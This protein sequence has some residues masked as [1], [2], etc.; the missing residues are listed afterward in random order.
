MK[1]R[2]LSFVVI[3]MLLLIMLPFSA[4]AQMQE[5][6]MELEEYSGEREKLNFNQ[7]WKFI[8]KN[9][10]AAIQVDYPM[11]ELTRWT[12]VDL[13]HTVRVEPFNNSGGENYQGP[14]M[15]R[16]HFKLSQSYQGKKLFLEFEGVMGVTDVW[17]NGQHLQGAMA[18]KTGGNTQ[19][20]G[21]LPFILDVTDTVHCDGEYNVITVLTDNSD[22]L[23]V[24]PGKPQSELDFTY[25]GGIYRNVWMTATNPVHITDAVFEDMIGGGGILVDYKKVT[26]GSATAEV[27]THIRN[28]D[29]VQRDV[30]LKTEIRN[31]ED[32]AVAVEINHHK[33]AS[34]EGYTFEQSIHVVNPKLWNLDHPYMYKLV[35][36]VTVDGIQIDQTETSIG[37]RKITMN[38]DTGLRINGEPAGFLSGI[39][40]HQEYPYI[41]YAASGNLQRRDAIK[42]KSAG[43]NIVRTAH[44]PQSID[45]LNACDELG[46]LVM[47]CVPGW[48]HWSDDEEFAARVKNDIRQMVRRSRNHPSVLCYEISLNETESMPEHLKLEFP[49]ECN[50]IAKSEHPS[51][52]TSAENHRVGANS[53]I[54]YGTPSEVASWSDTAMSLI[55]EYADNWNEQNGDFTDHARVTRGP[56]T[57]YPGGEGAM[58]RQAANKLWNGYSFVGTGGISLSQGIENYVKSKHRFIGVTMW[59]GIDHNRGCE[60]T[61]SPCGL[62]D[63]RRIP[64]YSYYAF[65]SQRPVAENP[66]LETKDVETG[67]SIFIAS[68]WG[69]NAPKVD[70]SDQVIGSDQSRMIDVYSNAN[71]VK[72]SVISYDGNLLWTKTNTPI[73]YKTASYLDHPPFEFKDVPYTTGSYLKAEGLDSLDK[74]IMTKEMHTAGEPSQL[75]LEVDQ[76]GANLVADGSDGVMAYAYVLDKDGNLCQD[77]ANKLYFDVEGEGSIIGDGDKRVGAN[78]INAEAGIMSV[79]I[80]STKSQGDIKFRVQSA[81]LIPAEVTIRSDSLE[82]KRV[83]YQE[84]PQGPSLEHT[85]MYLTQKQGQIPGVNPPAIETGTVSVDGTDYVNSIKG[86]NMSPLEYELD[87]NYSRFTS[88]AAVKDPATVKE[89]AIFKVYLDGVLSYMSDPVKDGVVDIDVDVAGAKVLTLIGGDEQAINMS[90]LLWLS[91]YVYEGSINTDESELRENLALNQSASASGTDSGTTEAGAV[92]GNMDTLWRSKE[93]VEEGKPQIWMLDLG[94]PR[95]LRNARLA[96]ERDYI[97]CTYNLYTSK[98]GRLWELKS[99]GSKTAHGNGILDK[100]TAKEVQYIKVEFVK[101]ESTQGEED[102]RIPKASI[103]EFEVYPD[104]GVETVRD[105]NLKGFEIAGKDIVFDAKKRE[106]SMQLQGYEKGYRVRALAENPGAAIRVNGVQMSP[107][108]GDDLASLPYQEVELD[109]NHQ[110]VFEVSSPDGLGVKRYTVTAE[111]TNNYD[112][113]PAGDCFVPGING[114]NN[115]YYQWMDK[116]TGEIWDMENTTGSYVQGEYAWQGE[117][118]WIY[119]GPRYMHPQNHVNAVRTFQAPR[120]GILD[121]QAEI[122]KFKGQPQQ[123]AY[124]ILKNGIKIW[125]GDRAQMV[126]D[127]GEVLNP[128]LLMQVNKGDKIQLVQDCY[129]DN[130]NDATGAVTVAKYLA[131]SIIQSI[132]IQGKDTMIHQK[133]TV[134]NGVYTATA[135]TDDGRTIPEFKCDWS[136]ESEI[137]GVSISQDG[138]LTACESVT[139]AKVVIQASI[140]NQIAGT[141]SVT[142]KRGEIDYLSDLEWESGEAGYGEPQKDFESDG[143]NPIRLTGNDGVPILYEKG[144]GTHAESRIIYNVKDKG[145]TFFAS[146][147][148]VDYSQNPE[149]TAASL[150]FKVYINGDE[151]QAIY[152]SGIMTYN[153]PQKEV[154]IPLDSSVETLTLYVGQGEVNYC[155][156][157]NWADARFVS[158]QKSD[159][160]RLEALI[161]IANT[162]DESRYTSD[163]YQ[164]FAAVLESAGHMAGEQ[165]IEQEDIN[166]MYIGLFKAIESLEIKEVPVVRNELEHLIEIAK[167]KEES[168]YTK[169]EWQVLQAA[170]IE[171]QQLLEQDNP[172]QKDIDAAQRRLI[173]AVLAFILP[174]EP[175]LPEEPADKA[176]LL[177]MIQLAQG[178]LNGNYTID[179]L[180]NLKAVLQIAIQSYKDEAAVQEE[181]NRIVKN[182][183]EAIRALQVKKAD[184]GALETVIRS[185][186]N[187]KKPDYTPSSWLVFETART[188]AQTILAKE[189][190]QQAEV[191]KAKTTLEAAIRSL[192]RQPLPVTKNHLLNT[193][194]SYENLKKADYTKS[195]W[196]EYVRALDNAKRVAGDTNATQA[197]VDHSS[198]ALVKAYSKL[199][200]QLPAKNKIITIGSGRYQVTRSSTRNGTVTYVKPKQNR[201]SKVTIPSTIKVNS[202]TFKVT[203]IDSKAFYRNK[204]IKSVSIGNNVT[205]IGGYAFANCTQLKTVVMGSRVQYIGSGAFMNDK[206][207]N[208]LTI[209]GKELRTV[210]SKAFYNISKKAVIKVAAKKYSTYKNLLTKAGVKESC[211]YKKV[212]S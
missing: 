42:F 135:L 34:Q 165:G 143:V 71:K 176:E 93:R 209:K 8:R 36:S 208:S 167:L 54:L 169:E 26:K 86:K 138:T 118:E 170:M 23:N 187:L 128:S 125:P 199:V 156:H 212:K 11:E 66:Y 64:K 61:M 191:D 50:D 41:G 44:T 90:E 78:P 204:K 190:V 131:P 173:A 130:G 159:K 166:Q 150:V 145:Y 154:H 63:L 121:Y 24:P 177:K 92:D 210:K 53:D 108:L 160:S 39:N 65:E 171:A 70:K 133:K 56:G 87:G 81:G 198:S 200:R 19:Y 148:G 175:E 4:S 35:S 195:S 88:W 91:P 188:N 72:L 48:Q 182:L 124:T 112:T 49:N 30:E 58:V 153:T 83:A 3:V 137:E 96:V 172:S 47:E 74:V 149:G 162:R 201:D 37:I 16:K 103:K 155:D 46:I 132:S 116:S 82:Q 85:S 57:F 111:G 168:D 202:Y 136:L 25:F 43:F 67:P 180:N 101:A 100:F 193:I 206:N 94:S 105:Y 142:I 152:N 32:V 17:I 45:F 185:S 55:R 29:S 127:V 181:I 147:V 123:T 178:E 117:D 21:Y 192:Q 14:A 189:S 68:S 62:W 13:P 126:L 140:D 203:A 196:A 38:K 139:Y 134:M 97:L 161:E 2:F 179:S 60:N 31:S 75:K 33:I 104:L 15:Y 76:S 51:A 40:R 129:G 120:D 207:L 20:G 119:S 10:Q 183:E 146:M 107:G 98:D 184:K 113:F 5:T 27:K 109:S 9:V 197:E 106:Y 1:Q 73:T 77:A 52:V 6:T 211:K 102:G 205:K 144:I 18:E 163:S 89:G 84:I 110:I 7:G 158:F 186:A 99:I 114:A 174:E 95:N 164:Q 22:N 79:L 157:A 115:W 28:E 59:I 194:K 69:E 141:K 80:Q 12:N 151:S 122:A